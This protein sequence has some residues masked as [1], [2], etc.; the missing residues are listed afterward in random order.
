MSNLILKLQDIRVDGCVLVFRYPVTNMSDIGGAGAVVPERDHSV[1]DCVDQPPGLGFRISSDFQRSHSRN[2][3]G[4]K[5]PET[6]CSIYGKQCHRERTDHA[7][8]FSF[9]RTRLVLVE[10]YTASRTGPGLSLLD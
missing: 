1:R 8:L 10:E 7:R 4:I 2:D 5:R 9:K 3:Q 6:R